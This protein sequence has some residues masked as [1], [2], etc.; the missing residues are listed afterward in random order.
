MP[1]LMAF[2]TVLDHLNLINFAISVFL[3]RILESLTAILKYSWFMLLPGSLVWFFYSMAC[4][5]LSLTRLTN[6]KFAKLLLERKRFLW[7]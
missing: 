2:I 6:K 4:K 7:F 5:I 1:Q 3:S